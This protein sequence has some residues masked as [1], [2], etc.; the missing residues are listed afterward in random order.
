[1]TLSSSRARARRLAACAIA[2]TALAACGGGGGDEGDAAASFLA[3]SSTFLPFRS[4]TS[5]HSDGPPDD[6]TVTPDVLGP[7]TQYINKLPPHGATEFPVGT[8]IVE[9]RE[10]GMMK[11]FAGVKRGAG[12]NGGGAA[13]WEWFELQDNPVVIVWRGVGP[14]L[15]DTYGGDPNGGCNACHAKCGSAND[16]VCSPKLSLATF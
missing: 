15:G 11:I 2:A 16:Y 14:P 10:S 5:F 7:R 13:G 1:M 12:F 9:A 6:G 4:W 8:V 3:F